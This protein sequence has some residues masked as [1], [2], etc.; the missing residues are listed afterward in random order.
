MTAFHGP[1]SSMRKSSWG[2]VE[3]TVKS[4]AM[5]RTTIRA[6]APFRTLTV[7]LAFLTVVGCSSDR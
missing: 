5:R 4:C 7:E 3:S 6:I 2:R 1:V